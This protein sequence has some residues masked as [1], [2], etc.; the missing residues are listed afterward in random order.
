MFRFVVKYLRNIL[1]KFF[2]CKEQRFIKGK[3][4]K[5]WVKSDYKKY[6]F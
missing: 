4:G 6:K 1:V 3:L 5:E 2:D